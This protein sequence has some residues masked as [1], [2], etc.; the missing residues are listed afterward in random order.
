MK[1]SAKSSCIIGTDVLKT[2]TCILQ[3]SVLLNP[4][5]HQ[6]GGSIPFG[7]AIKNSLFSLFFDN[8][9]LQKPSFS[10]NQK[11]SYFC[12]NLQIK[13]LRLGLNWDCKRPLSCSPCV[14]GANG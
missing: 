7:V 14:G 2:T 9:S 10:Q 6:V 1:K 12:K 3:N 11:P 13:V 8:L 5:K 4:S